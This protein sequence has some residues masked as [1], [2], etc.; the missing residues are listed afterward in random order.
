VLAG[1]R[2]ERRRQTP[3]TVIRPA[4]AIALLATL[5]VGAW[6]GARSALPQ[7]AAAATACGVE[8][9][10]VKTL[11]DARARLVDLRPRATTVR[12]LRALRAPAVGPATPRLAGVER[13]TYR[14][15]ARLIE[16][17]L[18]ADSDIHLVIADPTSRRRT[19]IVEFPA[20]GC[21]HGAR[22]TLRREMSAA[23]RA[24]IAA[25]GTPSATRFERLSG[26]ATITGVGF[27]DVIHGQTGVAPDGI[28]LHPVLGF[29]ARGC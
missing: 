25:C 19:M 7:T 14:L 22:A 10:P 5:A 11:T 27:F 15:R 6:L 23:R 16:L 20:S 4:L 29:W 9:W 17:K 26:S 12:A 21:T 28:E 18:E 13:R 3:A 2:R 8:R 24:V 1:T